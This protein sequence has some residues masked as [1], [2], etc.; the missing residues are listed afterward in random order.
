M[1]YNGRTSFLK[2]VR[3]MAKSP[4]ISARNYTEQ[5]AIILRPMA[6]SFCKNIKKTGIC[7]SKLQPR[8]FAGKFC[9]RIT[10]AANVATIFQE[11]LT[12]TLT[13]FLASP[14]CRAHFGQKCR[15]KAYHCWHDLKFLNQGILG[16]VI[17]R[18]AGKRSTGKRETRSLYFVCL[19]PTNHHLTRFHMCLGWGH[20][21]R[22]K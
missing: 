8:L 2:N 19:K 3:E 7:S 11:V 4:R 21:Q 6:T 22:G 10:L 15:L 13:A 1:V 12:L 5:I 16:K 18:L 17:L 14:L 9:C 20:S